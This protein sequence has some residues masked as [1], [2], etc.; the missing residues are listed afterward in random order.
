[1]DYKFI[2]DGEDEVI[3]KPRE[4]EYNKDVKEFYDETMDLSSLKNILESND[5]D[6]EIKCNNQELNELEKKIR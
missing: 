2:L 6:N 1:M 3:V 5:I 4:P